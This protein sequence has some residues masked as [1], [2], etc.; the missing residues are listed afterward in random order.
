M[1]STYERHIWALFNTRP[2]MVTAQR[3]V[4]VSKIASGS[5]GS[6]FKISYKL[7]VTVSKVEP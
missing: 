5:D 1:L 6:K 7:S 3:S 2:D 4:R